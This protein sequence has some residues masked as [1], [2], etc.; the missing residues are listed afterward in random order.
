MFKEESEIID[1]LRAIGGE[2]EVSIE[3]FQDKEINLTAA[4][5]VEAAAQD[6]SKEWIS[7][8]KFL[9]QRFPVPKMIS[10]SS[11]SVAFGSVQSSLSISKS[12]YVIVVFHY[13]VLMLLL[14]FSFAG[15][16]CNYEEYQGYDPT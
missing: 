1:P 9:M 14:V 7:F 8:K 3:S 12:A 6:S 13:V 16:C 15:F 2:K 11:V 4:S 5:F 10:V